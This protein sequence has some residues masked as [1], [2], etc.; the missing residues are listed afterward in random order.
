MKE[1]EKAT[2][3]L[4]VEQLRSMS[5]SQFLGYVA[6][7]T[8]SDADNPMTAYMAKRLDLIAV[9]LAADEARRSN[10]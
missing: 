1:H 3:R 8:D 10:D 9:T 7:L 5:D 6:T 4:I 2:A